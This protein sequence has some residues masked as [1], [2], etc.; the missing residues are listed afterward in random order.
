M[1]TQP[2]APLE[3]LFFSGVWKKA[4]VR[5]KSGDKKIE[6]IDT[7]T[8]NRYRFESWYEA[9]LKCTLIFLAMPHYYVWTF[10]FNIIRVPIYLI[11]IPMQHLAVYYQSG[12]INLKSAAEKLAK[13]LKNTVRNIAIAPLFAI[14][15]QGSAFYGISFPSEGKQLIDKLEFEWNHRISKKRDFKYL[16]HFEPTMD[17]LFKSV[18]DTEDSYTFYI[19]YCFQKLG[20]LKTD[21]NIASYRFIR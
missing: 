15:V 19:A 8:N 11:G 16:S 21:T 6:W 13:A 7:R 20:N 12:K 1:L 9:S 4:E 10:V 5:F 14:A 18:M 17:L 2:L 3:R